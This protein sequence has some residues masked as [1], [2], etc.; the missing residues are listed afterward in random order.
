MQDYEEEHE[1][2]MMSAFSR[3]SLPQ[4]STVARRTALGALGVGVLAFLGLALGGYAIFGL[5]MCIGLAMALANFRLIQAATVKA[6][7][8]QREDKRRPLA[9]N[10]LGRMG[11]ITVVALGLV[12]VSHQLGFGVLLGLAVF[13]FMLLANVTVAM[14]RD[15][16]A[17]PPL[18]SVGHGRT[19]GDA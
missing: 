10:T 7:S 12:F 14:L 15:T 2:I 13:Q 3:F 17:V 4:I 11:A 16:G 1:T 5:G 8:S 9:M 6:A 19:G 18:G